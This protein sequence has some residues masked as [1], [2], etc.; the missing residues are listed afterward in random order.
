VEAQRL[1]IGTYVSG[2]A[3]VGLLGW[4]LVGWG[5]SSDPLPFDV[6]EVSVVS[7]EEF[8][9]LTQAFTPQPVDDAPSLVTPVVPDTATPEPA[10]DTAPQSAPQPVAPAA[11]IE[12][13]PPPAAPEPI[14]QP[15][16]VQ[17]DAPDQPFVPDLP[18]LGA[19]D[20]PASDRPVPRP[21][22]RI[23]DTP[24]PPPPPDA[25]V[26]PVETPPVAE[27]T[28]PTQPEVTQETENAAP[29]EAAPRLVTE[30]ET[31]AGS[32]TASVRPPTRPAPPAPTVT[33]AEPEPEAP[34]APA[35]DDQADAIAAAVAAAAATT[36]A[37]SSAPQGPPLTG[38]EIAGFKD[39]MNA[40]WIY[41]PAGIAANVVLTVEFNLTPEGKVVN[42]EIRFVSATGGDQAAFDLAFRN[43]R[44]TIFRCQGN[45]YDLPSD[46]YD[47]WREVQVIFDPS[48]VK[49]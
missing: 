24:A 41:D 42:N 8:A 47:Q 15:A 36:P 33:E 16:E 49:F 45:G 38:G 4:L 20:L 40:C 30:A 35:S 48:G 9:A 17:P 14:P 19:P 18:E 13:T 31:P 1:T 46:K 22:D 11:P 2:V 39:A 7:S 44:S 34:S 10:Q 21:A 6:A 29:E 37:E 27:R 25:D 43:A 12:E 32:V 28:E 3:H 23:A 5:L 26:A